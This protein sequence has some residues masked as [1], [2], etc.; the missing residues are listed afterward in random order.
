MI[1]AIVPTDE[2]ILLLHEREE[3]VSTLRHLSAM[4]HLSQKP[5]TGNHGVRLQEFETGCGTHL[6]ADDTLQ[7][8]LYRQLING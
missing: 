1:F 3:I 7:I 8:F 2:H 5:R 6:T 4:L